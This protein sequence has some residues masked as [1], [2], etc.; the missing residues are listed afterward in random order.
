VDSIAYLVGHPNLTAV[1]PKKWR[2]YSWSFNFEALPVKCDVR[3][4]RDTW[5]SGPVNRPDTAVDARQ[6]HFVA[7]YARRTS[8]V[9]RNPGMVR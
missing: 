1:G 5:L 2:H 7:K 6:D 3:D 8:M 4:I 9:E